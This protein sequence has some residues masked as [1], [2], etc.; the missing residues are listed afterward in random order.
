[1]DIENV[2]AVIMGGLLIDTESYC[3]FYEIAGQ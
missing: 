2:P 1:M 3:T